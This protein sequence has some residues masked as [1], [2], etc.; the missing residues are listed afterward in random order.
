MVQGDEPAIGS[1]EYSDEKAPRPNS[2]S[3]ES[4][5]KIEK[6]SVRENKVQESPLAAAMRAELND[7]NVHQ[8][9]SH[10]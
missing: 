8:H 5:D 3:M 6:M 10:H 9:V 7:P 1:A 2:N 4:V